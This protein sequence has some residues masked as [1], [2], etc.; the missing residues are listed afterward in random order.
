LRAVE[1][2][3]CIRSQFT[4]RLLAQGRE[5]SEY[6]NPSVGYGMNS[7]ARPLAVAD[8]TAAAMLDMSSK[9]FWELVSCGALPGPKII[10][11]HNRWVVSD[12]EAILNGEAARPEEAFTV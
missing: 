5:G 6:G 11:N 3:F 4:Q 8:K 12:L 2:D 1:F 7:Y 9:V 10:G